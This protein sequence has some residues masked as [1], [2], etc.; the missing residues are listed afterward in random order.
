M[1]ICKICKEKIEDSFDTCWQCG[2]DKTGKKIM[3][4]S[5]EETKK[6]SETYFELSYKYGILRQLQTLLWIVIVLEIVGGLIVLINTQDAFG[7][8]PIW[9]ILI[10]CCVYIFGIFGI[11]CGIKIIDFLFELD[12]NKA[13][14]VN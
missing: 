12:K 2:Y 11:Y 1:W 14:K 13:D 4:E 5:F 6:E 9:T 7:V 8:L 3:S 10:Y